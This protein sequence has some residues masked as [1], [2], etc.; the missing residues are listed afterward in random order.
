MIYGAPIDP[1]LTADAVV[2]L[3]GLKPHP[4]GGFYRETWRDCPA[5][6]GRGSG[7]AIYYLLAAGEVSAWH[8]IDAVEIWH[9]YGGSPLELRIAATGAG[10][11]SHHLGNRL[12]NGERP[13][14]IVPPDVWQSAGTLGGWTLAGCTVSPA[15]EF[16]HFELAPPGW[17]PAQR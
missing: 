9:W 7:T 15:F 5:E 16:R 6:G 8:R 17:E 2:R 12:G 1:A 13:Q 10:V 11:V 14:I 4:E 3:L